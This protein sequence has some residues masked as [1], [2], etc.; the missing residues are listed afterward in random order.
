MIDF[1]NVKINSKVVFYKNVM[2]WEDKHATLN[3]FRAFWLFIALLQQYSHCYVTAPDGLI[4]LVKFVYTYIRFWCYWAL[5]VFHFDSSAKM[6]QLSAR[7]ENICQLLYEVGILN[8]NNCR[9]RSGAVHTCSPN[10]CK[11]WNYQLVS[12]DTRRSILI[13]RLIIYSPASSM[14]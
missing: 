13:Y 5:L 1:R 14:V 6:E 7:K 4:N 10:I 12:P 2:A 3:T 8:T 9:W 11:H